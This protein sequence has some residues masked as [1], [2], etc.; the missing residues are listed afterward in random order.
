MIWQCKW[1]LASIVSLWCVLFS[2][3]HSHLPSQ[4]PDYWLFLYIFFLHCTSIYWVSTL[5]RAL[6]RV[7][8]VQCWSKQTGLLPS[9]VSH[10]M[11][12]TAGDL[13]SKVPLYN[14]G[15]RVRKV[16]GISTSIL[17][18]VTMF[19]IGYV[20]IYDFSVIFLF[21]LLP[22]YK[23][24]VMW[25][26]HWVNFWSTDTIIL[27]FAVAKDNRCVLKINRNCILFA[28]SVM[29]RLLL[30]TNWNSLCNSLKRSIIC[31]F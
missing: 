1:L 20:Y 22:G 29:L 27:F 30:Q 3:P 14:K 21:L 18:I 25:G 9:W 5:C 15:I 23:Q 2:V 26:L 4:S 7:L 6:C 28:L 19:H 10:L 31:I 8:H 13:N 17:I 24:A 11:A 12:E 16:F